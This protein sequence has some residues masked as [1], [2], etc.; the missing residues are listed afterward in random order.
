MNYLFFD[1][2][3]ASVFKNVAK[4]CAFGYV[5]CDEDFNII[6]K[7]DILI[8]P[9]GRFHLTDGRGE[10]GL[11]LPYEY[12][13]FK[14]YPAFPS[15]YKKIKSLLE[16]PENLVFGHSVINDVKYLELETRRFRLPSFTFSFSD[17]QVL[18]MAKINDFSRQF[19]LEYITGDLNVEF[20]P[21]RAADD[22]YATMKIVEAMCRAENLTYPELEKKYGVIRGSVK[23][24][25]I[26]PPTSKGYK[27]FC[28]ARDEK[29]RERGKARCEFYNL[30]NSK[31][32]KRDGALKGLSVNFSR[33]LEER[34]DLSLPLVKKLYEKGGRYCGKL[35]DCNLY[36]CAEDDDS[37]R[38]QNAKARE[39]LKILSIEEFGKLLND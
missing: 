34:L 29:K 13:E 7:E 36:V 39:N 38:T 26:I 30:V 37:V 16:N 8:N 32:P 19:G 24:Y 6:N 28:A 20:T 23:K 12:K 9:K 14:N 11:V 3:C 15:V 2:E 21:H 22:A 25:V 18:Y 1:I 31:H 33:N 5:L 4:I 35:C 10:H 27:A 17:S